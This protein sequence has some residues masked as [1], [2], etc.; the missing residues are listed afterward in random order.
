LAQCA[1]ELADAA[2]ESTQAA[3][4]LAQQAHLFN[5]LLAAT[6]AAA[7][8]AAAAVQPPAPSPPKGQPTL[9]ALWSLGSSSSSSSSSSP[10]AARAQDLPPLGDPSG[11]PSGV[12]LGTKR[13]QA[14]TASA[15]S[16]VA[17]PELLPSGAQL[18]SCLASAGLA[19][20]FG[21]VSR[22]LSRVRN[23]KGKLAEP[24][25][26][27]TCRDARFGTV[28][29][30]QDDVTFTWVAPV[31]DDYAGSYDK[32]TGTTATSATSGASGAAA[33]GTAASAWVGAEVAGSRRG[34]R[35]RA[36]RQLL[37]RNNA[38]VLLVDAFVTDD[39]CAHMI[40]AA[41]PGLVRSTVNEEGNNQAVS[42]YRNSQVRDPAALT[43][44]S[45]LGRRSAAAS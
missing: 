2:A 41:T 7:A 43:P 14:D 42:Q 33:S 11:D 35:A 38:Q 25:R 10:A 22:E 39:E 40:E 29:V 26:N 27:H 30:P 37:R 12:V 32:A 18:A 34:G 36:V 31:A 21:A 44:T 23:A 6:A 13:A 17:L 28:A 45:A 1:R 20:D 24:L 5:G 15:R 9:A 3:H 8:E 19:H 4:D 16:A